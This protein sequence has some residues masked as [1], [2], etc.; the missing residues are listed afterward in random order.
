MWTRQRRGARLAQIA[1]VVWLSANAAIAQESSTSAAPPES[2]AVKQP[3]E[4]DLLTI[5]PGSGLFELWGHSLLCVSR[6]ALERARCYDFGIPSEKD[7]P[8]LAIGTL[9]GQALFVPVALPG[10]VVLTVYDDRNVWRQHLPLDAQASANL[11]AR[12]ETAVRTKQGYAYEP[13]SVNCSSQLRDVID[14]AVDGRLRRG[15]QVA[16]GPPLRQAAEI[17]LKDQVIALLLVALAGGS[18]SDAPS[19]AWQRMALPSGLSASVGTELGAPA[20]QLF[21]GRGS[22]EAP[23]PSAGRNVLMGLALSSTA[24]LWLARR[25]GGRTWAVARRAVGGWLF[26]WSLIPLAGSLSAWWSLSSNWTLLVLV[27]SDALLMLRWSP[28]LKRYVQIRMVTALAVGAAALL[29]LLHQPLLPAVLLAALPLLV[30]AVDAA[31]PIRP[32][33]RT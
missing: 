15:T 5:G 2:A 26:L 16:D 4:W 32:R 1:L 6:G 9:R 12:L 20:V 10:I 3:L 31:A 8:T 17:G 25:R 22:P 14:H 11:L 18:P 30:L 23:S 24:V 7:I 29:N 19:S 13:L 21:H 28:R 27:P 33:A